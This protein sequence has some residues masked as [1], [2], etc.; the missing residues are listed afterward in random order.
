MV[1]RGFIRPILTIRNEECI[2]VLQINT[3]GEI[4]SADIVDLHDA[5]GVH[6]TEFFAEFEK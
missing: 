5:D 6:Y 3:G 2:S 4:E 1:T